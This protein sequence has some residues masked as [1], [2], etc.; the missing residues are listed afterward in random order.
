MGEK[1]PG[2][3]AAHVHTNV[4]LTVWWSLFAYLRILFFFELLAWEGRLGKIA[5]SIRFYYYDSTITILLYE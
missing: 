3:Y 1:R 4:I 2:M 5:C